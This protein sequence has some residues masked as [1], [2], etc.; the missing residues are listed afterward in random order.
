MK[1]GVAFAGGFPNSTI[2]PGPKPTPCTVTSV[3]GRNDWGAKPEL[4]E[5]E[6]ILGPAVRIWGEKTLIWL[7]LEAVMIGLKLINWRL[8]TT[9]C[10]SLV[11]MAPLPGKLV[12]MAGLRVA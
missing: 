9:N 3:P 6:S 8:G 1:E 10:N 11:A 4:G 5:K 12:I 7:P 2:H